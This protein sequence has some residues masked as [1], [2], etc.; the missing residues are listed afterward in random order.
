MRDGRGRRGSGRCSCWAI[1]V[2]VSGECSPGRRLGRATV[3][4]T[5]EDASGYGAR[6]KEDVLTVCI[7]VP[8]G[9]GCAGHTWRSVTRRLT[10][11]V[12]RGSRVTPGYIGNIHCVADPAHTQR[13]C[14]IDSVHAV[15]VVDAC[16][17]SRHFDLTPSKISDEAICS[18][19]AIM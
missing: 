5:K 9:S 10:L 3:S 13:R 17:C 6:M 7:T 2:G 8:S 11:R 18:Q 19:L 4:C 12:A 14:P 15:A 16:C 1:R